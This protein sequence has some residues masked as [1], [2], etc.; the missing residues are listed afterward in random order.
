MKVAILA[1][2]YGTRLESITEVIPKP[3]ASIGGMPILWHIMKHYSYYGLNDFV[4][5]LGYKGSII[6]NFFYHYDV[7][8]RNFTIDLSKKEVD[9]HN[10]HEEENWKVTL[11]DTGVNTLKGARIKLLEL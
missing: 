3:M 7:Y 9:F 10:N 6:K 2:G 4:I 5:A 1:G 11:I 8:K